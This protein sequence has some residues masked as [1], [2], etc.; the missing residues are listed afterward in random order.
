MYQHPS[1]RYA[2][3]DVVVNLITY[4]NWKGYDAK[5]N[6]RFTFLPST[7]Y[8]NTISKMLY[9]NTYTYTRPQIDISSCF[10][11]SHDDK[12]YNQGLSIL[13]NDTRY[14]SLPEDTYT[15]KIKQSEYYAYVDF[16]YK[17]SKKHIVS[18]KVSFSDEEGNTESSYNIRKE[19]S[20]EN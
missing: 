13:G 7:I 5:G 4:E 9:D 8:G 20:H 6:N 17:I 16:D 12:R 14:Y 18:A 11:F 19:N 3:Y 2:G 1:G 15:S 10:R